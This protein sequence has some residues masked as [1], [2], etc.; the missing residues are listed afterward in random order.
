MVE[1]HIRIHHLH[2]HRGRRIQN[3]VSRRRSRQ[4]REKL[5]G[6]SWFVAD[7]KSDAFLSIPHKLIKGFIKFQGRCGSDALRGVAYA[8]QKT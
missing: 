8:M 4:L 1:V 6:S 5:L 7:E 2:R 3:L